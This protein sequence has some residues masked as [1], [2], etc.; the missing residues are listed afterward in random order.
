[1]T[2]ATA[3]EAEDGAGCTALATRVA[4]GAGVGEA[5]ARKCTGSAIATNPMATAPAPY[6]ISF[7]VDSRRS[8]L[9]G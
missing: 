8:L 1:L 5:G 3:D 9:R 2:G 6:A 4:A 7:F